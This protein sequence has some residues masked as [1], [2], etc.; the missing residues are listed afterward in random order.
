MI[1]NLNTNLL[2]LKLILT[3]IFI[4]NFIAIEINIKKVKTIKILKNI[5][6]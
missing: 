6:K 5:K 1:L 4:L 3:R 2:I